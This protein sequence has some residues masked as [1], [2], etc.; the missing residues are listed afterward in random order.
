MSVGECKCELAADLGAKAAR[1][2][3]DECKRDLAADVVAKRRG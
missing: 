2:S 3:V 1:V